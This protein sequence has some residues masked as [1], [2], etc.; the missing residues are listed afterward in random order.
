MLKFTDSAIVFQEIPNEITLAV[1]ISNCKHNCPGC[2]SSYLSKDIGE[3]LNISSLD[4]LIERN[5]HI[6]CFCFMGGDYDIESLIELS[7]HIRTKYNLKTAIYSG[8][9]NTYPSLFEY[10]DYYKYGPYIQEAGPL[11]NPNTNQKLLQLI[12]KNDNIEVN[13]ITYKFWNK[14]M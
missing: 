12:K 14:K 4:N 6:T 7:K 11:N 5:P 3:I 13:D 9:S 2:H 8:A 10:M 1:N